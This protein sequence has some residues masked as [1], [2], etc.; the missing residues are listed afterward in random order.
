MNFREAVSRAGT[1]YLAKGDNG[2]ILG[3][4]TD[5]NIAGIPGQNTFGPSKETILFSVTNKKIY[6]FQR[7]YVQP[8]TSYFTEVESFLGFGVFND[9]NSPSDWGLVFLTS[10]AGG[11]QIESYSGSRIGPKG[12]EVGKD[13]YGNNILTGH[14]DGFSDLSILEVFGFE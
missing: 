2:A 12:F 7:P 8:I 5:V 11:Y 6:D 1:L 10:E 4:L 13:A 14:P 9:F 3:A